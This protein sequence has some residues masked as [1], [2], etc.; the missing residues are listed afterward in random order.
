MSWEDFE[1]S[2]E[3]GAAI[4]LDGIVEGMSEVAI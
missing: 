2:G 3:L 1:L 4:F